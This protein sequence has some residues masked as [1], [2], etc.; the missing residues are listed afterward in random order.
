MILIR[1]M[2]DPVVINFTESEADTDM[3]DEIEENIRNKII[4]INDYKPS[5][6]ICAVIC[7]WV[8]EGDTVDQLCRATEVLV[9]VK[10]AKIAK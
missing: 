7:A 2:L 8:G 9:E 4:Y 3:T 5:F 1:I 10:A 6:R